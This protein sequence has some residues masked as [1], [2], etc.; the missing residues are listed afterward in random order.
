MGIGW[1]IR[2]II[3][4]VTVKFEPKPPTYRVE[5]GVVAGGAGFA[6]EL[7]PGTGR[8]L[9]IHA[10]YF[11]KPSVAVTMRLLRNARASTLGTSTEGPITPLDGSFDRSGAICKLFTAAP[12]AGTQLG[13]DLFEGVIGTGDVLYEEFGQ[14]GQ[15]PLVLRGADETLGINVSAAVTIVGYIEFSEEK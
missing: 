3:E 2:K 5:I 13:S 12:T 6:A 10:V 1:S 11:S 15:N 14:N 9:T 4:V 7:I 8:K